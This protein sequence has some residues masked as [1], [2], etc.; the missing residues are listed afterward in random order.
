MKR[1]QIQNTGWGGGYKEETK[2][3]KQSKTEYRKVI[4]ITEKIRL[5]SK[6][7]NFSLVRKICLVSPQTLKGQCHHKCVLFRPSDT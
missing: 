6:Y 5:E 4:G 1:M 7:P 2:K 3:N